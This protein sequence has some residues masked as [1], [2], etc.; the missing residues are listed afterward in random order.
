M[1]EKLIE[2]ASGDWKS[3]IE[4]AFT[5]CSTDLQSIFKSQKRRCRYLINDLLT[6]RQK[7]DFAINW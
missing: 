1:K 4:A 2:G 7:Y 6:L 5:N 3:V